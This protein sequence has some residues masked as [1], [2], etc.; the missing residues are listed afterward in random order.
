M[1][2]HSYTSTLTRVAIE[3]ESIELLDAGGNV[4]RL[5][6]P[7]ML[8]VGS[9]TNSYIEGNQLPGLVGQIGSA[10]GSSL[11]VAW[12]AHGDL[13]AVAGEFRLSCSHKGPH[14][15]WV[16]VEANGDVWVSPA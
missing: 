10:I 9:T 6:P 4:C 8:T 2:A 14:E 16:V 3:V 13:S 1:E 15:K 11:S 7:I 12:D 5:Y